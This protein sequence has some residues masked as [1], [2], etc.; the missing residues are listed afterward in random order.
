MQHR[1]ALHDHIVDVVDRHEEAPRLTFRGSARLSISGIEHAEP[2]KVL[3][4]GFDHVCDV[5]RDATHAPEGCGG[6]SEPADPH[7][8]GLRHRGHGV[9]WSSLLNEW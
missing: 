2:K 8:R 1:L 7:H 9:T 5:L 4:R 6:L 3:V